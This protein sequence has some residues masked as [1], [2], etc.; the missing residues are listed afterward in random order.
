MSACILF[1]DMGP[2]SISIA[3]PVVTMATT[4]C[5]FG[6]DCPCH[7]LGCICDMSWSQQ[8]EGNLLDWGLEINSDG[9]LRYFVY[10]TNFQQYYMCKN[11]F[12]PC[13]GLSD[14][15]IDQMLFVGH[16]RI[17]PAPEE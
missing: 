4:N 14:D 6:V 2:L 16:W 11:H 1:K 7:G 10:D 13:W 12:L 15:D 17:R 8:T 3:K 9:G 5:V